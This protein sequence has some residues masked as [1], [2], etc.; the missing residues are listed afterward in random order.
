VLLYLFTP[1]RYWIQSFSLVGNSYCCGS[2]Y[3][4]YWG[5]F[6]IHKVWPRLLHIKSIVLFRCHIK[7][8]WKAGECAIILDKSNYQLHVHIL[9][10]YYG[11]STGRPYTLNQ[12]KLAALDGVVRQIDLTADNV[13]NI[14]NAVLAN[15]VTST[16]NSVH[17]KFVSYQWISY[18]DIANMCW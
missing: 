9:F 6:G 10:F 13:E 5:D 4:H 8:R 7:S 12:C 15:E 2:Y 16:E 17:C 18:N 11:Y 1:Y 3:N 14:Y